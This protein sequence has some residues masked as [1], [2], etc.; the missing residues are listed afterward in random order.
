MIIEASYAYDDT[1]LPQVDH[2]PD[3]HVLAK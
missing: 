3:L 2:Y 1:R